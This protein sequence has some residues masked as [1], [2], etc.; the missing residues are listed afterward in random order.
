[1]FNSS[2]QAYVDIHCKNTQ[3]TQCKYTHY[4]YTLKK[5]FKLISSR[6]AQDRSGNLILV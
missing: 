5:C 2:Q 6:I 4:K 1:M 3:Y